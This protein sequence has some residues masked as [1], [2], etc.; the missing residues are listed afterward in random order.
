MKF[1]DPVLVFERAELRLEVSAV[2]DPAAVDLLCNTLWGSPGGTRYQ[3]LDTRT[4]ITE[5][6]DPSFLHLRK[7]AD[8][9]GVLSLSRRDIR[10][11]S[12][13][14]NSWYIRYFAMKEAL[15]KKSAEAAPQSEVIHDSLLKRS[16]DRLTLR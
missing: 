1:P 2:P 3:H 15:Q 12:S 10:T 6:P 11:I 16:A 8:L 7:G 5:I 14:R 4:R 9:L 13:T